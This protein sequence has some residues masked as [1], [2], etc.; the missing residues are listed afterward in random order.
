MV[1]TEAQANVL[2]RSMIRIAAAA[3]GAGAR[4]SVELPAGSLV[5]ACPEWAA[6]Q[7][8]A[9]L[10]AYHMDLCMFAPDDP[11]GCYRKP[12]ELWTNFTEAGALAVRCVGSHAHLRAR[13]SVKLAGRLRR[14]L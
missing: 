1:P 4:V 13:G 5:S 14:P 2:I 11:P 9:S 10:E 12:V 6:L 7:D 8:A 3:A